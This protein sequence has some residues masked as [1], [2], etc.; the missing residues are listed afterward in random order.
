MRTLFR[1]IIGVLLILM[2]ML[3]GFVPFI[4]GI[5]LVLLGLQLL[6]LPLVN[7]ERVKEFFRRRKDDQR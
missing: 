4:P 7:W 3:L 1:K 6:G 2:G 5:V